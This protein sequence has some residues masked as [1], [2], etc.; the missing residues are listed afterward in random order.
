MMGGQAK[1][2]VIMRPAVPMMMQRHCKY[3]QQEDR[4][5]QDGNPRPAFAAAIYRHTL[6]DGH[7]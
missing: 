5:G 4:Q 6:Q 1:E 3:G 7:K 2:A